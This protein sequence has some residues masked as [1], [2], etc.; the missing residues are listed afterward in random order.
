[1]KKVKVIA[2]VVLLLATNAVSY[3]AGYH[4]NDSKNY[5]VACLQADFIHRLMDWDEECWNVGAEVEELWYECYQD[6]ELGNY[7]T[8]HVHSIEDLNGYS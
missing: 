8:K 3:L 7:N 5:E 1:M 4:N 2:A 6:L